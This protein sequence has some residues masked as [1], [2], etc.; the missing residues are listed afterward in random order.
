[1]QCCHEK[2]IRRKRAVTI[3]TGSVLFVILS[4]SVVISQWRSGPWVEM[5]RQNAEKLVSD[6]PWGQTQVDTDVS[7]M[8]FS[9]TRAGTASSGR[10][11]ASGQ[12]GS[13]S[14][15]NN[16]RADRGAVNQAVEIRYRICFLSARPIRE[17]FARLVMLSQREPDIDLMQRLQS[18]VKRDFS[19]YIVIAVTVDS[20]DH[21]FLGPVMQQVNS[22]TTGTLKKKAYLE[23]PDGKRLFLSDYRP[24]VADGL[25]AKFIFPRRR[26]GENF[27]DTKSQSVRFVAEFNDNVKL[28]MRFKVSEMI[29]DEKLEY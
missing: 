15:I 14:S 29:Y 24:P 27:L 3:C 10:S 20:N 18:F 26:N 19:S 11:A 8:F 25:G 2:R 16:K 23:R 28:N 17:A 7:E 13:Q 21:R 6:S 22:A 1:M 4:S 9:P 5:P 12:L